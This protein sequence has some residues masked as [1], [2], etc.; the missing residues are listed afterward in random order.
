MEELK[1][2]LTHLDPQEKAMIESL[3]DIAYECGY[4][5]GKEDAEHMIAQIQ[6]LAFLR[7]GGTA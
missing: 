7:V 4:D 2:K 6:H 5:D 1:A 3:L